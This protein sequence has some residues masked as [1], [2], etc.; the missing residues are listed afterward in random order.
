[1]IWVT[2]DEQLKAAV[3]AVTV[4]LRIDSVGSFL[5]D[6][7]SDFIL[8]IGK[9]AKD[10]LAAK[11]DHIAT[12]YIRA[13]AVN[14]ALAAYASSGAMQISDAGMHVS[15]SDRLLPASDKKIVAFKRD[16]Y[17]AGWGYFEKCVA[18]M[19]AD[20]VAFPGWKA[21]EE[22]ARYMALFVDY[23]FEFAMY[24]KVNVSPDLYQRLRPEIRKTEID[25]ISPILGTTVWTELK[26]RK[27]G[28]SGG[29]EG[30]WQ[31]LLERVLRA[32]GPL[33]VA[34]ALLYQMVDVGKDGVFQL[35]EAAL[36]STSDNIEARNVVQQRVMAGLLTRLVSEGE[37]ELERLRKFLNE[38]RATFEGAPEHEEA[39]LAKV[40]EGVDDSNVYFL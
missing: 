2:T 11:P 25:A 6:V 16:R 26:A 22:R 35:S 8:L 30:K 1:M 39:P 34:D 38:N 28:E 37:A 7:E 36:S 24:S 19:E 27:N 15:K 9:V 23:S 18:Q 3:S 17:K 10:E 29:L 33:A 31:D 12:V 4:D 40:N 32:L 13:A 21:S 14:L 20:E 5:Q